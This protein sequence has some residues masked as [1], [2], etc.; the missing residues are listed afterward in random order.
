M[1][2]K[3]KTFLVIFLAYL[4]VTNEA[5]AFWSFLVKAASK[6]LPSLIGGG[7]DNKSSSKRKREI[8]DFFDPYQREL[9]L[10]LE[11]LLSQLQ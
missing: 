11:R 3:T 6:I 1:Q 4:V 9:D 10:E 2:Y 5:E 7:D 8:E